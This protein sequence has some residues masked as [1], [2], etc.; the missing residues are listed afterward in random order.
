MTRQRGTAD[1]VAWIV[2][3]VAILGLIGCMTI[4]AYGGALV[5][6]IVGG[7]AGLSL[8]ERRRRRSAAA[9]AEIAARAECENELYLNGDS[10]GL[11]GQY[12]PPSN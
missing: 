7:V 5:W 2:L 8:A 3:A 11:Y 6:I 4:S 1:V 9:A 10:T 12:R